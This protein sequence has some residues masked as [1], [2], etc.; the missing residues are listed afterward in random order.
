[1]LPHNGQRTYK[2]CRP[3]RLLMPLTGRPLFKLL[4][5]K[6]LAKPWAS[7]EQFIVCRLFML[8]QHESDTITHVVKGKA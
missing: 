6:Y 8:T 4:L 7:R 1:M 5:S 2:V 3:L